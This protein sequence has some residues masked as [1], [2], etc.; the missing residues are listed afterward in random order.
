MKSY[1]HYNKMKIIEYVLSRAPRRKEQICLVSPSIKANMKIN[2][3]ARKLYKK[4]KR[5][6]SLTYKK[7]Y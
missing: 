7:D 4:K 3:V 2:G 5:K 1:I 6:K